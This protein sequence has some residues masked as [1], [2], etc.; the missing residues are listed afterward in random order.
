[1][2]WFWRIKKWK[3]EVFVE[4]TEF[5]DSDIVPVDYYLASVPDERALICLTTDTGYGILKTDPEFGPYG[6]A[7]GFALFSSVGGF[8]PNLIKNGD[9]FYPAIYV[10][11]G[12]TADLSTSYN[13]DT[14]TLS[15]NGLFGNSY[16]RMQ[17]AEY[18]PYDPG[19]GEGPIY[20]KDTGRQLRAFP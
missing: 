3:L 10:T 7:W 6:N 13:A 12:E 19:D 15:A 1:M 8:F 2:E 9:L 20:D 14:K 18:W 5:T 17:P 16:L 4:D 11:F